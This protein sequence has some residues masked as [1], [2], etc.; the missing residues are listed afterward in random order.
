ETLV[1][2]A[3]IA[4]RVW[5][6]L[7]QIY[8]ERGVELRGDDTARALIPAMKQA[9]GAEWAT[10]YMAAILAVRVVDGRDAAIDH[11]AEL[12]SQHAHAIRGN[13]SLARRRGQP[14]VAA[15]GRGA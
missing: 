6:R 7:C 1:V 15:G 9:T 8:G 14:S 12:S 10:A 11:I 5:P 2:H 13:H 4:P 3:K